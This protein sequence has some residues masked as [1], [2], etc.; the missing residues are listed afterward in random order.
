M[1]T[2]LEEMF[3][4]EFNLLIGFNFN[5]WC[6]SEIMNFFRL[7]VSFN[8][9]FPDNICIVVLFWSWLVNCLCWIGHGKVNINMTHSVWIVW[10]LVV[11]YVKSCASGFRV[12]ISH[13]LARTVHVRNLIRRE[14]FSVSLQSQSKWSLHTIT[15]S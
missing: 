10:H 14:L 11:F 6:V 9:G 5:D 15:S 7:I 4:F 3:C 1:H 8:C 2:L 12:S 13:S